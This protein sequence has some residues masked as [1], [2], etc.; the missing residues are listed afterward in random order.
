MGKIA[1]RRHF[2][3]L[4]MNIIIERLNIARVFQGYISPDI[5]HLGMLTELVVLLVRGTNYCDILV[6]VTNL[7]QCE[8]R[9]CKFLITLA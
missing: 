5:Y 7:I 1:F 2:T 4:K 8:V 9:E 6:V 3:Q